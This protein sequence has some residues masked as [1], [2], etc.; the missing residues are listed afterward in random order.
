MVRTLEFN[1]QENEVFDAM[2]NEGG[3]QEETLPV[4]SVWDYP[5]PPRLE[6]VQQRVRI[7]A[8]NRVIADTGSAHR[9]LE[10]SHPPVYYLPVGDLEAGCLIRSRARGSFCEF[11]GMATYWDLRL[12]GAQVIEAA[13]WSYDAPSRAYAALV[14]TV[15]F[16]ASRLQAQGLVCSVGQERVQAQE[17]DFY[18]G[19]IT[20]NLRGPFKGAP[21][22]RGW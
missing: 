19:W 20:A 9:I 11:K 6:R 12:S 22:T 13:G 16:Y 10:T 17:G 14:G 8:G 18:G 1:V 21:D 5:R 2:N 15:A 4:E 7:A 3:S